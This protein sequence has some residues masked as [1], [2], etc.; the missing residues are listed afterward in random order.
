MKKKISMKWQWHIIVIV[1]CFCLFSLLC[2][3]NF[4]KTMGSSLLSRLKNHVVVIEEKETSNN[5]NHA[6]MIQ[7]MDSL[8]AMWYSA[9]FKKSHLSKMDSI[10]TYYVTGEIASKQVLYGDGNWLFYKSQTDGNPIDDFEGTNRYTSEEMEEILSA[11]LYTQKKLENRGIKFAI[12]VAPN[13]E[14]VYSK[15][16]PDTYTHADISSS[17]IL[18]NYLDE[19]GV[20]MVNPKTELL[21]NCTDYQ[22]YYSYD[23]H[24]NQLGAY[25]GVRNVLS[26]WKIDMPE[27]SE[28]DILS[29]N[30][31]GNYHYCGADDLAKMVGLREAVFN[32]EIEYEVDGTG[33]MEWV[34]FEEE[35]KS[36]KVSHY[37]NPEAEVNSS[38]LLVG[39]SFRASMVAALREKFYDVYVV[40]RPYYTADLLDTINPEYVI[41]EYV[42]RYLSNI[43]DI[44][45]MVY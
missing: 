8:D 13:K 41:S 3:I 14:N 32:D 17:D 12:I 18:I 33:L 43:G 36:G 44:D 31:Y 34:E 1:V 24:W 4:A 27:L 23:T 40:D 45:S 25:I 6:K 22:L 29:E 2:W 30:L 11:A 16:M 7:T 10:F 38:I 42:E 20:N 15:Y 19:N 37:L 28:R 26:S 5:S 21:N 35:Q 39:D 9:I